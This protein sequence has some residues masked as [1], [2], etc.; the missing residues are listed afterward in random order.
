MENSS[1]CT[2]FWMVKLRLLL[3]VIILIGCLNSG[4]S[5]FGYNFFEMASNKVDS[6]NRF[7]LCKIMCVLIAFSA[8]LLAFSKETWYPFL[9]CSV[10]PSGV[11]HLS[12]P[13]NSD[14][15]LKIHVKP[16]SK[17]VY[18]AAYGKNNNKQNVKDAYKDYTNSGVVMSDS[19]GIAE[20]SIQEGGGYNVPLK[21][22]HRHIHYRIVGKSGGMLGP[23]K[24]IYY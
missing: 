18:W 8:L 17:V 24:T 10:F 12:V 11:L 5:A 23:V 1:Y 6:D 3:L 14:I 13:N 20:L 15:K 22:L 2:H 16:N 19:N 21:K 7:N 4:T 9:G